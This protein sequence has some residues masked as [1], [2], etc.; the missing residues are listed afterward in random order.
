VRALAESKLAGI[1]KELGELTLL[2][3]ELQAILRNWDARLANTGEGAQANLL[4]SLTNT[5]SKVRTKAVTA[6]AGVKRLNSR[7]GDF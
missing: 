2:R 6:R 5:G 7:K 4:E 3:E 1:E